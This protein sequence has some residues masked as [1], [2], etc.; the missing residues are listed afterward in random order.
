MINF[1]KN[2]FFGEPRSNKW[3][4]LRDKLVKETGECLAC[5]TKKELTCHHIIPF[6]KNKKLEL[7]E[8]NLV[9]LCDTCHFVFGHL[10]SWKSYNA[11]VIKDSREY[12][13]K[14]EYR[15]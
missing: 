9:V 8:S 1:F 13:L 4:A 10:K 2:L 15:P 14:V 6:S 12:R 5:G 3:P 7:E 11:N